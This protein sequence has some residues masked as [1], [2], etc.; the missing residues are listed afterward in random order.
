M[1]LLWSALIEL[2]VLRWLY[3]WLLSRRRWGWFCVGFHNWWWR[4]AFDSAVSNWMVW[5]VIYIFTWSW[6][7][8]YPATG[9]LVV[10]FM[11]RILLFV[12]GRRLSSFFKPSRKVKRRRWLVIKSSRIR[13]L[14]KRWLWIFCLIIKVGCW[15]LFINLGFI[16]S[17][18]LLV[19]NAWWRWRWLNLWL[20]RYLML[21]LWHLLSLSMNM[22]IFIFFIL[23]SINW[24]INRRF[25]HISSS[26]W[27]GYHHFIVSRGWRKILFT[28]MSLWMM[29]SWHKWSFLLSLS[30]YLHW[31]I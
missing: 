7:Y 4:R 20:I 14:I 5:C 23:L 26:T 3:F 19:I 18:N 27:W 17:M 25:R 28:G 12:W 11:S 8:V 2:V 9:I 13:R 21:R 10:L 16:N 22:L 15:I 31:L 6:L 29:L 30:S 1:F 24:L